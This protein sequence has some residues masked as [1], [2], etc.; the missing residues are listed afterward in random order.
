MRISES[1][2]AAVVLATVAS[3]PSARADETFSGL[4]T[5]VDRTTSEIIVKQD[6]PK[7]NAGDTVGAAASATAR[8]KLKDAVPETLHAGERVTVTYTESNG[9]KIATK[10]SEGK[11]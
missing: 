2:A 5:V 9:Q 7:Q 3:I 11:D 4:V 6:A 1:I 8:F 10:V